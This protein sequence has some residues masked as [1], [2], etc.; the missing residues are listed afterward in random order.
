M[1]T[2]EGKSGL[3]CSAA[4]DLPILCID[5]GL[6]RSGI[7]H[8]KTGFAFDDLSIVLHN[9]TSTYEDIIKG[10][11]VKDAVDDIIGDVLAE[12]KVEGEEVEEPLVPESALTA[13]I[14]HYARLLRVR[15]IVVG[16]P[17][18]KDGNE[19]KQSRIVRSFCRNE[20]AVSLCREFGGS[21]DEE[22]GHFVPWVR[23]FMFDERYSS[24]S[25]AAIMSGGKGAVTRDLDAVS[26]CVILSHFCKVGGEGAEEVLLEDYKLSTRL[27]KEHEDRNSERAREE[28]DKVRMNTMKE[29]RSDMIKR[30]KEEEEDKGGGEGRAL[31]KKERENIRKE[32]KRKRAVKKRKIL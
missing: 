17:L 16:L 25:A 7:A 15:G 21:W 4:V 8:T 31:S 3:F 13:Q 5:H 30:V 26:A 2:S 1:A 10:R 11:D 19:S 28:E 22:G 12:F 20:L 32:G 27:L 18:F 14:L 9:S 6:L 23:L 24:S 29:S